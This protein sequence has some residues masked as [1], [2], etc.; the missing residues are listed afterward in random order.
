MVVLSWLQP[1]GKR[2][3]VTKALRMFSYGYLAVV[4]GLYLQQLGLTAFQV[5][6]VLTAAVA[7]S[8]LMNVLW[9]LAADRFGRRRTVATMAGLMIAGGLVFAFADQLW[10]LVLG[11]FTGTISA[12]S[13][14]VGPFVTVEQ[15]ILP[16]TAPDEPR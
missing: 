8:T 6:V 14:E 13:A 15:A 7:G 2:L 16:Q 4:L 9:S 3:L 5:G 10:L 12:S 1:D 11:A